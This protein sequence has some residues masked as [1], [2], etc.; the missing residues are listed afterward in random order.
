MVSETGFYGVATALTIVGLGVLL[1]GVSL[2]HGSAF[3]E[4]IAAGGVIVAVGIGLIM[5]A[6]MRLE[7]AQETE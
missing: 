5:V 2:N 6:V 7:A 1:Y 4:Q 3:N